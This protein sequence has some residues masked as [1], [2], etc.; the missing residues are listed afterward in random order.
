MS[1]ARS[2]VPKIRY[3]D[4]IEFGKHPLVKKKA[5]KEYLFETLV[6]NGNFLKKVLTSIWSRRKTGT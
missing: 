3:Y 5:R 6:T 1:S 4:G 2:V